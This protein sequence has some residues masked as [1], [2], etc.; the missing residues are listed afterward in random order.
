MLAGVLN[1]CVLSDVANSNDA[2]VLLFSPTTSIVETNSL[3]TSVMFLL[4]GCWE[5]VSNSGAKNH[6]VGSN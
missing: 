5:E 2:F 4:I 6:G 1:T 3:R